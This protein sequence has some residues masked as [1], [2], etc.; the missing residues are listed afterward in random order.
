[1]EYIVTDD[2]IKDIVKEE[3]VQEF[4]FECDRHN[5]ISIKDKDPVNSLDDLV[6]DNVST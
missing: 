2:G 6:A 4:P 1:M 3:L 5:I